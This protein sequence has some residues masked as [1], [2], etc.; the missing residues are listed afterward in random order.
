MEEGSDSRRQVDAPPSSPL[1]SSNPPHSAVAASSSPLAT[2]EEGDE[3]HRHHDHRRRRH[4]HHRRIQASVTY[5]VTISSS[6]PPATNDGAAPW[7][8]QVTREDTWSCLVVLLTFW[9]FV[10]VTLILGFYGS[11]SLVLGP[12]S[13]LLLHAN[14]YFVQDIKF[15]SDTDRPGPLL[16]GFSE[17]PPLDVKITWS[18]SHNLSIPANFHEE[19][20]YYLNE[21][22]RI[23][24]SY[25]VKLQGSFPLTLLIVQG[26]ESF[27][28]WIEDPL[29]PMTTSSWNL[30]NGT[31]L[32]QQKILK[33]SDYYIALSNLNPLSAE[34]E[35]NI[36]VDA[37]L[38]NTTRAYYNCS[39]HHDLCVMKLFFLRTN[40]AI[41]ATSGPQQNEDNEWI[42]KLSYGPRWIAYFV[43]SGSMTVMILLAL[44]VINY[45]RANSGDPTHSQVAPEATYERTPLLSNEDDD[46][47]SLGSSYDSISNDEND[48]EEQLEVA[49][50][51]PK[52]VIGSEGSDT[53]HLCTVCC[54]AP[55]DC[56][57]LPCGH[58]ATCF[59]CGTRVTEE[60]GICPICR[61]RMKKVK[62]IFTV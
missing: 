5:R 47:S 1:P 27:V 2:V 44:K 14:S 20:A 15:Q 50:N 58:C 51:E 7:L 45:L 32:V 19:W 25:N 49:P 21:G 43:G 13:S 40:A 17:R 39:L 11:V 54:D 56:F 12:N 55:K 10:S 8:T 35:L 36:E 42:I 48:I 23:D 33:S 3:V 53:Q 60:A 4:D 41:L 62:K 61:R 16:Y 9:F 31:G 59:T 52:P 28:K 29:L 24:I 57:F 46:H 22:S 37:L 6:S 18:E 34:V 30:V 26:E 38:Y